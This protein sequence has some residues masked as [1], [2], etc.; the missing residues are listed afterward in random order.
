MEGGL[1]ISDAAKEVQVE[2][3][4][5][6]Y[7]EEELELPIRRNEQGHRY[8]TDEDV[9]CFKQIKIMKER[10]LQL[11]A[12]KLILKDGKFDILPADQVTEQV[13]GQ[14]SE[15]MS[16]QMSGE[17]SEHMSRQVSGQT[18]EHVPQQVSGQMGAMESKEEKTQRLQWVLQQMIRQAVQENNTE[19]VQ[20]IRES[21]LK[22]LDYQ[23][24]LQEEREEER[25]RKAMERAEQHYR[26]VD[27]LLRIKSR[28]RKISTLTDK[29]SVADVTNA[30]KED[31]TVAEKQTLEEKPENK[32]T[33]K[34]WFV[35]ARKTKS[36]K[37]AEKP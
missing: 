30:P 4:V 21:V 10:G 24:R 7:W 37:I 17:A 25:D 20:Q 35:F 3:H 22:E 14:A 13:L 28:R 18:S 16:R 31:H 36:K 33:G 19:L 27:E 15:H 12:I 26:Q 29:V 9:A 32:K 6:R 5:L 2:S 34:R 1:L 23:F 8:Y 11:K